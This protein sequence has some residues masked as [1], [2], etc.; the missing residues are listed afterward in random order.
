MQQLKTLGISADAYNSLL[1][2]VLMKKMPKDVRLI[3]A[4]KITEDN[5]NLDEIMKALAEEF[6]SQ[7][8]NSKGR[9][10]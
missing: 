10:W 9:E 4:R 3:I 5:W 8:E 1:P 2:S 6:K 7:G